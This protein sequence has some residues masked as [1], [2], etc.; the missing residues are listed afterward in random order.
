MT[1]EMHHT[2][3]PIG[4]KWYCTYNKTICANMMCAI[5]Q[6]NNIQGLTKIYYRL[7]VNSPKAEVEVV[8]CFLSCGHHTYSFHC[9]ST[10]VLVVSLFQQTLQDDV[11]MLYIKETI[12]GVWGELF[13]WITHTFV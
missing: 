10:A 2:N 1:P 3:G 11:E 4:N 7:L 13:L 9:N 6:Y 12:F 8:S 5:V